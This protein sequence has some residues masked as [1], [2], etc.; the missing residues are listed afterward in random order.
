MSQ[1]DQPRTT[2][3]VA[4]PVSSAGFESPVAAFIRGNYFYVLS[5]VAFLAGCYL[6]INA[7][8]ITGAVFLRT[9]KSF[10]VLQGYEALLLA[11]AGLITWKLG[12][13]G[14]VTTLFLIALVLMFDPT[15]FGNAFYTIRQG[16]PPAWPITVCGLSL[17][18]V[19]A[20]FEIFRR[21]L[22]LAV[23]WRYLAGF[24]IAAC[25]VWLAG[26]I[27]RGDIAPANIIW[28]SYALAWSALVVTAVIGEP[29]PA[30][31]LPGD[32]RPGNKFS[33]FVCL[34]PPLLCAIHQI[35]LTQV[36]DLPFAAWLL[37]PYFIA[38][39]YVFIRAAKPDT[40]PAEWYILADFILAGALYV[41]LLT[42]DERTV[43]TGTSL[44]VPVAVTGLAIAG[45]FAYG[46]WR[47]RSTIALKHLV[48]YSSA[49]IFGT[50]VYLGIP[51]ISN[52]E[53][54][55]FLRSIVSYHTLQFLLAAAFGALAVIKKR[56]IFWLFAAWALI[57]FVFGVIPGGY[58]SWGMEMFQAILAALFIY[59]YATGASTEELRKTATLLIAAGLVRAVFFPNPVAL[60]VLL[61]ESAVYIALS[62]K[63]KDF[64]YALWGAIGLVV[65]G[66]NVAEDV[67]KNLHPSII[68]LAVGLILFAIGIFV[69]FR[70]STV[71]AIAGA[72]QYQPTSPQ[73]ATVDPIPAPAA[74]W[75][76]GTATAPSV[77]VPS[78][79]PPVL[80]DS[81]AAPLEAAPPDDT[82]TFALTRDRIGSTMPGSLS[83]YVLDVFVDDPEIRIRRFTDLSVAEV[84]SLKRATA[85]DA[86]EPLVVV[87]GDGLEAG[88]V[89]TLLLTPVTI[90]IIS[91]SAGPTTRFVPYSSIA[92]IGRNYST[93]AI[94]THSGQSFLYN[95]I[96]PLQADL[97]K[98]GLES[99]IVEAILRQEEQL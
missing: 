65:V 94:R 60:T 6:L 19:F 43:I 96:S 30:C 42:G 9:L 39:A 72:E 15:F 76:A 25:V 59:Y 1:A 26:L 14:D 63:L 57:G 97:V 38:T 8:F 46:Y 3:P 36:F 23:N 95:C 5:A 20:K 92:H 41:S 56:A 29:A 71:P 64:Y 31:H 12:R 82:D 21:L 70:K 98:Q 85:L 48:V 80:P 67:F 49:V 68:A 35:E 2:A 93:L 74:D 77:T 99:V 45:V 50:V 55:D 54:P 52:W 34:V 81:P 4:N 32:A 28:Y 13:G 69:T 17:V 75:A 79:Q 62:R 37:S 27:F 51:V 86:L 33:R 10:L 58:G 87:H 78:P 40:T 73:T 84:N 83:Q 91:G 11:T 18:A 16:V 89:T 44:P 88:Y 24:T 61:I 47:H 66:G 53:I 90:A 7:P 22:H